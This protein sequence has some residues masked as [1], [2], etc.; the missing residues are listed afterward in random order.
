M[1]N[2]CRFL[3]VRKMFWN[4]IKV[5]LNFKIVHFKVG[6]L[7]MVELYLNQKTYE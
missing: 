4:K 3:G 6:W 1:L 7:Y 2:G 5:A